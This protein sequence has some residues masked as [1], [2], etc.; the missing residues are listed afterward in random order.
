[1]LANNMKK[2][3][4]LAGLLAKTVLGASLVLGTGTQAYSQNTMTPQQRREMENLSMLNSAIGSLLHSGIVPAKTPKEARI[5][6][7]LGELNLTLSRISENHLR[8]ESL[9]YLNQG[10]G[11][12]Q[13]SQGTI[14]GESSQNN[15]PASTDAYAQSRTFLANYW[16]RN[17][18]DTLIGNITWNQFKGLEKRIFDSNKNETIMAGIYISDKVRD[19]K[20]KQGEIKFFSP[21]G[22]EEF[23]QTINSKSNLREWGWGMISSKQWMDYYGPG[24]YFAAFYYDGK[25]WEA[26]SFEIFDSGGNTNVSPLSRSII[27]NYSLE[28]EGSTNYNDLIGIDKKTFGKNE[29]LTFGFFFK[30]AGIKGKPLEIKVYN[31]KGEE[32]INEKGYFDRDF[33][34][35]KR[36]FDVDSL[37]E[38]YGCGTYAVK[39]LYNNKLY[40]QKQFDI[41]FNHNN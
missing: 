30:T 12:N 16:K 29:A 31:P 3:K 10:E 17:D 2:S 37:H 35:W 34:F 11:S 26:R 19:K 7:G 32:I 18:F 9:R 25:L 39:Y 5:M 22:Q 36:K 28:N 33:C 1:M 15:L 6:H 40:N 20:G 23:S 8:N 4:T 14:Q 27:C 24:T 41:K 38:K 13:S 21:A